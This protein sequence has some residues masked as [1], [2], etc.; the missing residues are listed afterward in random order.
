MSDTADLCPPSRCRCPSCTIVAAVHLLETNRP[1]MA[2]LLL[3]PLAEAIADAASA[4]VVADAPEM[5][6]RRRTRQELARRPAKPAFQRLAAELLEHVAR[7]GPVRVAELLGVR[8]ADL[9]PMLEGRVE[10]AK[11]ALTR[12]RRAE[13]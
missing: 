12:V 1:G 7:L 8:M 3:R 5:P 13:A 2:L 6:A 10:V 9:G 11:A 4:A